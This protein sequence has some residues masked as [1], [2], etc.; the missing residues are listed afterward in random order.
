MLS[1]RKEYHREYYI[2][3]KER[4]NAKNNQYY[5]ENKEKTKQRFDRYRK[6][7]PE[8][9]SATKRK[10]REKRKVEKPEYGKE[11][12]REYRKKNT[13]RVLSYGRKWSASNLDKIRIKSGNR[14]AKIKKVP[15]NGWTV[16]DERQ[17]IEDYCY[18][19]A[20]CGKKAKPTMDH[21][22][23]IA[24]G[25]THSIENIVPACQSCNSS[26]NDDSLLIWMYKNVKNDLRP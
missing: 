24:K 11:Y 25:G 13:E 22:V 1:D 17:L 4:I 12:A 6:E 19:C 26:K 10:S 20:Y 8:K 18:C 16:A 15:G 2:K 3:N 5:S 14:R 21:I 7:N 23:P 9:V